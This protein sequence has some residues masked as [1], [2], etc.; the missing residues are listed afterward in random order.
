M[1]GKGNDKLSR[2]V[3]SHFTEITNIASYTQYNKHIICIRMQA[4]ELKPIQ[5]SAISMLVL[6]ELPQDSL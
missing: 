5:Y 3:S 4:A 6:Q 1:K 2:S